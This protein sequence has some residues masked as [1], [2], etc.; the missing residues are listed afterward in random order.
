MLGYNNVIKSNYI[1]DDIITTIETP[2]TP[3]EC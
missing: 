1:Q 2:Q 3:P